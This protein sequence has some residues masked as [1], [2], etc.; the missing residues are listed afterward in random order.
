MSRAQAALSRLLPFVPEPPELR[1]GG[2]SSAMGKMTERFKGLAKSLDK[3]AARLGSM[4]TRR[5]RRAEA[6]NLSPMGRA[7]PLGPPH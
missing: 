4:P 6:L 7:C 2:D 3:T 1:K 5:A